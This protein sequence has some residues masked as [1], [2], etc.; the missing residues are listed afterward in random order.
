M[1]TNQT[2]ERMDFRAR[3]K[4]AGGYLVKEVN[5]IL[6][7]HTISFPFRINTQKMTI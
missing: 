2:P 4:K 7:F 3:N 5:Y 1:K 6:F